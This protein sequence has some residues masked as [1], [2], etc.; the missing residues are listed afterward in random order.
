M[1]KKKALEAIEEIPE[2]FD[3]EVLIERL[4]SIQKVEKSFQQIS[5]KKNGFPETKKHWPGLLI[6]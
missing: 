1:E 4:T 5:E 2:T 3:L 6:L